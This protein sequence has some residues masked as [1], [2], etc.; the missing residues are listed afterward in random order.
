MSTPAIRRYWSRVI[1]FGC[2][3]HQEACTSP[4]LEVAHG[5]GESVTERMQ[6]PKAKGRKLPRMDWIVLALCPAAHRIDAD[7][8]DRNPRAFERRYGSVAELIDRC[9]AALSVD[10]WVLAKVGKK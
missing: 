5:H 10:V 9:A 1:A 2:A 8:L 4:G 6:E 3:V 7:S